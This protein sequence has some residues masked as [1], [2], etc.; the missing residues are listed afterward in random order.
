MTRA[1]ALIAFAALLCIAGESAAAAERAAVA[2][3]IALATLAQ[4]RAPWASAENDA[5]ESIPT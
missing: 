4:G 5:G 3:A 1:T 2:R